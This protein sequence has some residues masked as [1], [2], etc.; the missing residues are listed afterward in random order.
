M[1][2]PPPPPPLGTSSLA[3]PPPPPSGTLAATRWGLGDA[4]AALGV[5][6]GTALVITACF[7]LVD[8]DDGRLVGPWL[9]AFV[10]LPQLL[11]AIHVVT[12]VNRK[13]RGTV[14][15]LKLRIK[16]IDLPIGIA[17]AFAGL[18]AAGVV[19]TVVAELFGDDQTAA[20]ADLVEESQGD[21]G[22]SGWIILVAV[23]GATLVPFAEELLFRGL[24]WSALVKRGASERTALVLT[25]LVFVAFHP[26]PYRSPVLLA[27][28]LALGWG[29]LRTGRLGAALVAHCLINTIAFTALV[30][31]LS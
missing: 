1:P 12:V 6:V 18:L 30:V 8:G 31:E 11:V 19:A 13:G 22:I 10:V 21:G 24:W 29:R 27:L 15:D 5:Y 28:G 2:L 23:L 7:L 25:S 17:V 4:F 16:W 20:V 3:P 26:E 14:V 9:P